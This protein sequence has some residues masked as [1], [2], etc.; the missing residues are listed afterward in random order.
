MRGQVV[1]LGMLLAALFSQCS[2]KQKSEEAS[3]VAPSSPPA[4]EALSEEDRLQQMVLAE[5]WILTHTPSIK[6]LGF[7]VQSLQLPEKHS[8]QLF[9]EIVLRT[10]LNEPSLVEQ[11][12]SSL[13]F[14]RQYAYTPQ[15]FTQTGALSDGGLW[16]TALQGVASVPRAKFYFISAQLDG[17][18]IHAEMGFEGLAHLKSGG[19]RSFTSSMTVTWR[20]SGDRWLISG[21]DQHPMSAAESPK[22]FFKEALIEHLATQEDFD[23][24]RASIH[25]QNLIKLFSS[26]KFTTTDPVYARY[27]DLE[28]S[29]QHPGL[30]VVDVDG[31]GWD[32]L[33]VMGRW[34]KN[35]LFHRRPTDG[36]YEDI[37]QPL[38]L[39]L[40]G[41][42]NGAIFADFD[43]DGDQDAFI[44]RSLKPSPYLENVRGRF[45]DR[46]QERVAVPLPSLVSSVSAADFNNDGL[47]D[48]YLGLYGPT[49]KDVSLSQWAKE[50]FPPAMENELNRRGKNSHRYLD[51]VGP[52]NLLLENRGDR[53]VVAAAAGVLAEWRNT[54]QS[55]WSDYD[56]DG[57]VDLYVCN[58]F[59]P[60]AMF[61]NEGPNAKGIVTFKEVS[62]QIAGNAMGGFGMGASWD[63]YDRDGYL[64]LFVSNMYSK[65]GKRITSQIDG[66]DRRVP[67]A[68]QGSLLMRNDAGT[69]KQVAGSGMEDIHVAKVGWSFGGL[70]VDAD[71]DSYPDIYSASGYYT[72]PSESRSNQDL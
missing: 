60:D 11:S 66:L 30:A 15:N 34:G 26:G 40:D 12:S 22:R 67:Y 32:E 57:D 52:P 10:D 31:D 68:A 42:C 51:M 59:A 29:H 24:A 35:Q 7:S 62:K 58:D 21:W 47:L 44:A 61:R 25:E 28:S 43:N 23:R 2:P 19:W 71:N 17:L 41:Y 65:A 56:H 49:S 63:D 55:A 46:S 5:E 13:P 16:S 36:L 72:A 27:Q 6:K 53:F 8:R 48:V 64:D 14:L 69:F 45:M 4:P 20:K 37:A 54:Y 33:Y 18:N 9:D 3:P 70:F 39:D 50:F 1:F 38:G